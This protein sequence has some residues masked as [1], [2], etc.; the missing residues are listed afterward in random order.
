MKPT[1]VLK[2]CVDAAMYLLFLLLM[3]QFLLRDAP[4]S[5]WGLQPVYFLFCTAH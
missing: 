4:M 1:T 2:I 3:G 5:G